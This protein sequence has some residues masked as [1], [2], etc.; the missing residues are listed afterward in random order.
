MHNVYEAHESLL[1]EP[2]TLIGYPVEGGNGNLIFSEKTFAISENCEYKD[3]AWSFIS[4]LLSEEFQFKMAY[5]VIDTDLPVRRDAQEMFCDLMM[6][7]TGNRATIGVYYIA[8]EAGQFSYRD[9]ISYYTEEDVERYLNL[10]EKLDTA[11]RPS[12]VV[13]K[14]IEEEAAYYFNGDKPLEEVVDVIENRIKTYVYEK[15]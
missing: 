6:E 4:Y 5:A 11:W 3:V 12:L 7:R 10:V 2:V 1:G 14:I 9:W 13:D 15:N 8:S